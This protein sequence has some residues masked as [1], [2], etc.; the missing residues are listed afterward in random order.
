MEL[1][2]LLS[3]NEIVAQV[4]GFLILLALLKAFAWKRILGLL[5]KR[6]EHITSELQGIEDAKAGIERLR[7]EYDAKLASIE[8]AAKERLHET[9]N[10]S[11]AILEDARKC[12]HLSAQEI[13]DNA[14]QN[15]KYELAK[16]K[17]ELK[18]EIIDMTLKATEDVIKEK[19]TG[20]GDRRLVRD[21]LEGLDKVE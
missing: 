13:I 9:L 14:R 20:E 8:E 11:K 7:I 18:N 17:D 21:F 12:A 19:L 3:T 5:D 10:A 15:V 2:K 6:R 1:L 16:A 4:I